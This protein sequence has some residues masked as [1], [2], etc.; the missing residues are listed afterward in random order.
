MVLLAE[1]F[2]FLIILYVLYRYVWPILGRMANQRQDAIQQ[3]VDDSEAEA[4]NVEDAQRRFET[5]VTQARDEVARIVDAARGDAERIREE[6]RAAADAEV[7]RI[8]ARGDEQL[9][10]Q[11]D[12]TVRQLRAET[13][14]QV[15]S[16]TRQLVV[17][18]LSADEPKTASVDRFL[19]ELD[20]MAKDRA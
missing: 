17:E 18:S 20:Q 7:E 12:Q 15:M 16:V 4:R 19:D 9:V 6:L 3:K 13:G 2:A 14:R 10:A 11:R 8:R 1:S 5:A